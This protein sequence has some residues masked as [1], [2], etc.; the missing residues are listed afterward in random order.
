[1]C[2]QRH[3]LKQLWKQRQRCCKSIDTGVVATSGIAFCMGSVGMTRR[4][5]LGAARNV[6]E[7]GGVW[8]AEK[9]AR[10]PGALTMLIGR[11]RPA[12]ETLGDVFHWTNIT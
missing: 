5:E 1:M 6:E 9:L 8:I 10:V 3:C 11:Q 4:A 7:N 2:W 12:L